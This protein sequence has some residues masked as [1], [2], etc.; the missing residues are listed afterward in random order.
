MTAEQPPAGDRARKSSSRSA[1]RATGPSPRSD[2]RAPNA[3]G[4]SGD[5]AMTPA[6]PS[7]DRAK[8][9]SAPS[10]DRAKTPSAPTGDLAP[11]PSASPGEPRGAADGKAPSRRRSGGRSSRP[12]LFEV[13]WEVCLQLGGIYQVLRSKAPVMESRWGDDYCLV[14]PHHG[15]A[16]TV[17]FEPAQATGPI[18]QALDTLEAAGWRTHFGRWLIS[19]RPQVILIEHVLPPDRLASAKYFLWHDFGLELPA[20][21]LI[22]EVVGFA[23]GC[24]ALFA[25]LSL[26]YGPRPVIAH[27]HEWMGGLAIPHLRRA[28]LPVAIVFT[29]HATRLGRQ[30]ASE[31]E[32]FYDRLPELD[33]AAEAR[34]YGLT[35]IHGIERA[36]AHGAHVFT[37]VSEVT[38]DECRHLLGR[39]ADVILPNGLNVERFL[40]PHYLQSL[41]VEHMQ[42]VHRFT[43][44]HFFPYYSFDLDKTLYMFTSGRFEPRNKGFDLCLEAM[45]RLNAE[46]QTQKSGVT[47]IFFI[48]TRR[49]GVR[50]KS[51]CLQNRAVMRELEDTCRSITSQ[52]GDRFFHAVTAGNAPRLDALVDDYWRLRLRRTMHAWQRDGLPPVVTHDIDGPDPVLDYI[53][54]LWLDN[55]ANHPVK[56]VYHPEFITPANPLWNMEY[57]QFVRGCHLGV[58]PSAY[59]PWGYTPLECLVSGVPAVSSDLAGFGRYVHAH[60][61]SHSD[62]GA[63]VV[64]RRGRSYFDSAADLTRILLDFC[65]LTRRDRIALRNRADAQSESFDWTHLADAYHLAHGRALDALAADRATLP[66]ATLP[67]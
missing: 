18:R 4:P 37:T 2:D 38:G 30:L 60:F 58:F 14:G 50:I 10:G 63:Y 32:D 31:R 43:R 20:D 26:A 27:F 24:H 64:R 36:C 62:W 9:P 29:T 51:R 25:A 3:P 48:V 17:E 57:D 35:A 56:I 66:R 5:R 49:D 7:G 11:T 47:V 21:P 16:T 61:A 55:A 65:Q 15:Q 6:A 28:R 42:Q 53:H 59:E 19:G 1:A 34:R 12:L 22:D 45:A 54:G 44:G 41:H 33:D 40:A 8:T 46:L 52:V 23:T 13:A 39:P 67:V